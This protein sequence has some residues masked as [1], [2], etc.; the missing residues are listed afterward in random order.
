MNDTTMNHTSALTRGLRQIGM[1][2]ATEQ[3]SIVGA[4]RDI[5]P[6]LATMTIAFVYGDI[7]SRPALDLRQRQF[8]TVA[9]LASMGGLEPQLRF[10]VA[11]ALNVGCTPAEIVELMTHLVVYAGFPAAVNGIRVTKDVFGER[12]VAP[13]AV[14]TQTQTQTQT[15]GNRYDRGLACLR[16]IDGAVGERVI[17]SLNGIAPDLG[18]FIIEFAFGEIYTRAGLDLVS[19]ELVT[20]AALAALGTA[21]P[22]LKVH[23]HGFLNVGGTTEQLVETVIQIAAYAGFPRAINAALAAKD[24]TNERMSGGH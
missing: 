10:H 18:R 9:A 7:Y 2:E 11:G 21:T 24:V 12:G 16:A 6:D 15:H 13:G 5:A 19:R 3:P 1:V 17:E 14:A 22:Q 4:L 20:V 8:V 23:M